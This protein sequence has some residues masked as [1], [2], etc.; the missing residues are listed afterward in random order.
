[1]KRFL[2]TD[3][4]TEGASC[5]ILDTHMA[6]IALFSFRSLKDLPKFCRALNSRRD[7]V[8]RWSWAPIDKNVWYPIYEEEKNA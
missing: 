5:G 3:E 1:M 6:K 4:T 7:S 2:V 8:S